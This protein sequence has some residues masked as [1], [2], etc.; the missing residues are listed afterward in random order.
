M[1]ITRKS[2]LVANG[3]HDDLEWLKKQLDQF[4][5]IVAIDGGLN[6][7]QACGCTPS[8]AIGDFDSATPPSSIPTHT[9]PTEKDDTDLSLALQKYTADSFVVVYGAFGK[10]IGHE[11]GNLLLLHSYPNRVEYRSPTT[12]IRSLSGKHTFPCFP[13]QKISF[14]CL[15]GEARVSTK[16][17]RWDLTSTAI[18]GS[19]YSISNYCTERDYTINVESGSILLT[20]EQYG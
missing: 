11:I 14:F 2:A 12:Q 15:N 13:E 16:G 8:E 5:H 3:A 6:T 19:F 10:A 17:L 9:F 20:V 18:N 4:S 7:L 1:P